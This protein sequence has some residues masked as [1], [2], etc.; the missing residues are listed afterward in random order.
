MN[1]ADALA[2]VMLIQQ[3]C[4]ERATVEVQ[5]DVAVQGE[6]LVDVVYTIRFIARDREQWERRRR[7]ID[8]RFHKEKTSNF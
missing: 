2:L 7:E 5:D 1:Y 4:G 6:Y 8:A 3:E